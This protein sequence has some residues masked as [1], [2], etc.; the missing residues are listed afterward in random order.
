MLPLGLDVPAMVSAVDPAGGV[1]DPIVRTVPAPV[2]EGVLDGRDAQDEDEGQHGYLLPEG[3]H[4]G[5]EVQQNDE[6]EVEVGESMKLL[7]EILGN[8]GEQRVLGGTDSVVRVGPVRVLAPGYVGRHHVVGHQDARS[9][10]LG[11]L[12]PEHH[13]L[14]EGPA[15][16]PD[17]VEGLGPGGLAGVPLGEGGR[18]HG[19]LLLLPLLV[20]RRQDEVRFGAVSPVASPALH[21]LPV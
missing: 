13:L 2:L 9:G 18:P 4:G 14:Q 16:L 6:E 1:V 19:R 11:N 12:F 17:G 21:Q 7:E 3:V 10:F 15:L 20:P 5:H 8:E